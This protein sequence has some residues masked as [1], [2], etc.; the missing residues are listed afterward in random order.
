MGRRPGPL[1]PA[2]VNKLFEG[3][4]ACGSPGRTSAIGIAKGTGR[5]NEHGRKPEFGAAFV[6]SES[7][8]RKRGSS[9]P[10]RWDQN[11]RGGL[12]VVVRSPGFLDAPF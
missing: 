5:A 9:Q 6:H 4:R 1:R 11:P 7:E 12:G 10:S 3:Y 2:L 8:S